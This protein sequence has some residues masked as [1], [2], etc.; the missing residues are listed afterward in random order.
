M[1]DSQRAIDVSVYAVVI[2]QMFYHT[3][4]LL[5]EHVGSVVGC[6]KTLICQCTIDLQS[7]KVIY[8]IIR[9]GGSFIAFV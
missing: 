2:Y 7:F 9:Y 6:F 3:V 5:C 8:V 4:F 1:H